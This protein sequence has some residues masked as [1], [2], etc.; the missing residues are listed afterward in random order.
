MRW[1]VERNRLLS[2][3]VRDVYSGTLGYPLTM[4]TAESIPA[5]TEQIPESGE[6]DC[7]WCTLRRAG[8]WKAVLPSSASPGTGNRT[9]VA[10]QFPV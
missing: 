8:P 10:G 1:E 5:L 9:Q 7:A 2:P 3:R 4:D 6:F